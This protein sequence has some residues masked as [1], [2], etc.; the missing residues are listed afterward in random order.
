MSTQEQRA[1]A[2]CRSIGANPDQV[3]KSWHGFEAGGGYFTTAPRWTLYLGAVIQQQ[4]AA[5]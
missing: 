2:Y 5:E 1:R 3:V 4:H